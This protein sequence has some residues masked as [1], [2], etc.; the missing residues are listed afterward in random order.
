MKVGDLVLPKKTFQGSHAVHG[1]GVVLDTDET[2]H[3]ILYFEV[4]W[5]HE[6]GWWAQEE[7]ILFHEA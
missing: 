3:G 1:I 7:M 2:D 4:Q 5:Q 6:R